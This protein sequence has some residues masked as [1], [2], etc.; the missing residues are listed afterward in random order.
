MNKQNH[1]AG[2]RFGCI[3]GGEAKELH[4][5]SGCSDSTDHSPLKTAIGAPKSHAVL[6]IHDGSEVD[7][8]HHSKVYKQA[9]TVQNVGSPSTQIKMER[10]EKYEKKELNKKLQIPE[11]HLYS[12]KVF[13][14]GLNKFVTEEI[15]LE[16]FS[17]FGQVTAVEIIRHRRDQRS[18]GL[19]YVTFAD[20]QTAAKVV[21][22]SEH[23]LQGKRVTC[24]K[25]F[26]RLLEIERDLISKQPSQLSEWKHTHL[27]SGP[28]ESSPIQ[29]HM[30]VAGNPNWN[31]GYRFNK[32]VVSPVGH[33]LRIGNLIFR[34][35]QAR[36]V[37]RT[38]A[39]SD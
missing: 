22:I 32:E 21:S 17:R 30:S 12:R 10:Y 2:W 3:Q 4:D 27:S 15:A 18:K 24:A 39:Y 35:Y 37:A 36:V 8:L 7:H 13:L 28:K 34:K 25:Y 6:R 1:Q 11:D 26:P 14:C 9:L 16:F 29:G 23:V 31:P 38:L 19:G 33:G 20:P 5:N